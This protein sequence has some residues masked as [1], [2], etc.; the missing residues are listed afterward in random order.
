VT[1]VFELKE[2]PSSG[3]GGESTAEEGGKVVF[4]GKG[5]DERLKDRLLAAVN[6]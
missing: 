4:I 2:L 3:S 6:V 5:V 1:D